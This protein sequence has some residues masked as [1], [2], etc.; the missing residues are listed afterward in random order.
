MEQVLEIP[1]DLLVGHWRAVQGPLTIDW[2]FQGNGT[3]SGKIARRGKVISDF[4][5]NWMVDGT[6]LYSEYTGD[7]LGTIETGSTDRDIFLEFDYNHFL[8][9]TTR[10]ERRYNRVQ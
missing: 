7:S 9:K 8:V 4:T 1:P 10:G 3:F 2:R 5:G 6:W